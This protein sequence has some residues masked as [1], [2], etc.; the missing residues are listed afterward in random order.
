MLGL[1]IWIPV[2]T[3]AVLGLAYIFAGEGGPAIKLAIGS[4]FVIATYLQ[5]GSPYP[6]IG[7]LLQ[8]VLALGL[9]TWRKLATNP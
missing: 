2:A 6:L 4:V 3:S 5:F 9:A 7:L 1:L 8:S